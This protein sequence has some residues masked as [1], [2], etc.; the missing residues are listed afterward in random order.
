MGGDGVFFFGLLRC[1]RTDSRP[2]ESY[3][4][5]WPARY[6]L[7]L[8]QEKV[9]KENTPSV[10]RPSLREGFATG[11]RGSADRTSCPAAECARSLARTRA[12]RGPDP[13][14]LRRVTEGP[15]SRAQALLLRQGLPRSALQGSL[16]AAASRRRK[17]PK[18]RAQDA[19]AF[20]ACTRT[21][22]QRT[23]KPDRV[24]TRAWM[25]A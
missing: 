2:C 19:R 1:A 13:S 14:A 25:P 17:S 10:P 23:P 12:V 24:V 7:L 18:G 3:R 20:A 11:G 6:F 21:Y 15:R 8:V 9:T 4:P 16:S 5:S 22:C